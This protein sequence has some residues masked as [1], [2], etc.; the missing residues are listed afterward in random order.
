[1]RGF[2]MLL[3]LA[4]LQTID[5]GYHEAARS[6]GRRG[7]SGFAR[8]PAAPLPLFVFCVD[9]RAHPLDQTFEITSR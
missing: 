8:S 1:M 5:P 2:Y 3:L 9:H 6:M 4:G 7:G